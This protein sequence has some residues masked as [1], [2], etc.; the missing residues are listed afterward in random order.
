[1]THKELHSFLE[2]KYEKYNRLDFIGSD[3]ISIPHKFSKKQDIEIAGFLSATIAWGQRPTIIRNANELMKRMDFT[4]HDFILNHSKKDLAQFKN[5]K[6]RTF[7]GVDCVFF[8]KSLQNIYKKNHSLEDVF[9]P[10]PGGGVRGRTFVQDSILNF[11]KTFFSI[12][13]PCRTGKH[14]SFPPPTP[15]SGG[16]GSACKRINM[17]LRWMIRKDKRGVDFGIWNQIPLNPALQ[18]GNLT[19]G[20]SPSQ[21]M[22]PLDIHSGNTARKLGLLTRKQNDWQSVEE[23]TNRLR[24]F[25]ASD[26]VKYDFALFGLGVFEKF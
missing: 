20:I 11:R 10:P 5:F 7:N 3:P 22:C 19:A 2:E 26:P 9:Y 18:G 15:S 25:D 13:H 12:P 16:H 8:I 17:F 14:V 1:M 6:H 24:K 23:L 21:L 4:P